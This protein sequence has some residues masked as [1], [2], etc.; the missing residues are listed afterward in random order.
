MNSTTDE[1]TQS[2]GK[3]SVSPARVGRAERSV[4]A[5]GDRGQSTAEYALL[6]LGVASIALLVLAW[7]GSTGAIGDLFDK[8]INWVSSQVA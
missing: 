8:V 3:C 1:S 4:A 2:G 5:R 7:A 6:I